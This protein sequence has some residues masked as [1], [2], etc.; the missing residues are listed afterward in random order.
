[1]PAGHR[2]P[3]SCSARV[4]QANFPFVAEPG[5]DQSA[6]A[7]L[8]PRGIFVP[9]P[10]A[11][12]IKLAS[13]TVYVLLLRGAEHANIVVDGKANATR[14]VTETSFTCSR[15]GFNVPGTLSFSMLRGGA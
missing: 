7:L 8:A 15:F 13:D 2:T 3:G 4:K 14:E 10:N 9:P 6:T 11:S 5:V 1:M 12:P